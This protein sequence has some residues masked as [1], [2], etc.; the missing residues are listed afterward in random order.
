[1]GLVDVVLHELVHQNVYVKDEIAFNE[2]L[3]S[4]ISKRLAVDFFR[5][6]G[7]DALGD[8]A[9]RRY[10]LWLGQSAVFD[11]FAARLERY[12]AVAGSENRTAMLEGRSVIYDDL[13]GR[14]R[15]LE[16][17]NEAPDVGVTRVMNNAVFLALWRY[18]KEAD[19]LQS[20]LDTFDAMGEAVADLRERTESASF[21]PYASIAAR[22]RRADCCSDDRDVSSVRGG[23]GVT[24][25]ATHSDPTRNEH[26]RASTRDPE[27]VR[28]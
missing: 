5:G 15:S 17:G 3:A 8:E 12:F 2:T 27:L 13:M 4:A 26:E 25:V 23:V 19:L 14:L 18:R 6:R 11:E 28:R 20:Y 22:V 21:D 16:P 10:T 9:E 1:V 24:L 7:E